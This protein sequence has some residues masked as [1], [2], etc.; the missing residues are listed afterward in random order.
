MQGSADITGLYTARYGVPPA[1]MK[2]FVRVNQFVDGWEEH[3]CEVL[4]HR[5]GYGADLPPGCGPLS[6]CPPG[7]QAGRR[8][9]GACPLL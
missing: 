6:S 5:P 9:P 2:V 7:F 4:G 3:A 8:P 1:G